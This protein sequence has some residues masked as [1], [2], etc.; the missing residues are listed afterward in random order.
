LSNLGNVAS[1]VGTTLLN[2]FG[3]AIVMSLVSFAITGVGKVID[4]VIH[5]KE[6][7]IQLAKET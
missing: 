7:A 3:S 5:A 1:V 2:A 6:N 4:S